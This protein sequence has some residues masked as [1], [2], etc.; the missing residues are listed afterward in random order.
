MPFSK[1]DPHAPATPE[2]Q[3][4]AARRR[5]LLLRWGGLVATAFTALG[6][7]FMAYWLWRDRQP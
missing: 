1:F 5:A 3:D 6:F 7:A 2:A 4:P